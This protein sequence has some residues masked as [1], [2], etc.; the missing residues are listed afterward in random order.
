MTL[1]TFND[2]HEYQR[3]TIIE[4][5]H[6]KHMA[7]L[8]GTGLGKTIMAMTL[9]DQLQKRNK[10]KG[11]LVVTPK[12][13]MYNT[14][15]QEAVQ[16][17]HTKNKTFSLIHGDATS[18]N[19]ERVRRVALFRKADFHLINYE[20]LVWLSKMLYKFY[21]SRPLPWNMIVY[22]ESTRM[23]HSTN[24]R[25]MRFK[26]YMGRFEYRIPMTG[27]PIPNGLHDI[28]GQMYCVD[29]GLSLGR[30]V[31]SFRS[32]FFYIKGQG[33]YNKYTP[34]PEAKKQVQDRIR[35]R[36]IYLKKTDHVK[37]PPLRFNSIALDMPDRFKSMYYDLESKMFAEIGNSTEIEVFSESAK[38][39]KLRQFLQGSVYEG[40]GKDRVVHQIHSEKLDMIRAMSDQGIVEGVGNTLIAYN[41]HF[42]R[43]DLWTVFP[44]APAIDG[45]TSERDA[46]KYMERWNSGELPVLLVN[47][48]SVSAGL[49][50][51]HGGNQVIWYS[52]TW[53]LEHY[54]QLIDR[55][56]RQGQKMPYVMVHHLIFRNTVDQT[57]FLSLADK[58]VTQDNMME[59]LKKAA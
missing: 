33:A 22:D 6:K 46:T 37:L 29:L 58:D 39:M 53:N 28:F 30:E 23:K 16:W 14:W 35:S 18:G 4:T 15:R 10:I 45:R 40:Q 51:Q 48:D 21:R 20:G 44:K 12:K 49:N 2:L 25:F 42:E 8:I 32:R 9:A 19:P 24:T 54:L 13:V 7:W 43:D 17:E 50:L 52:L 56:W 57:M 41:F 27:T 3:R 5:F 36:V 59:A 31:G 47:P 34:R 26:K 1:K 38:A 11:T 55:L